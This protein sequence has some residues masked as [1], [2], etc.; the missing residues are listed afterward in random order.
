MVVPDPGQ[1][2]AA[3]TTTVA[4]ERA[5]MGLTGS[6]PADPAT[7]TESAVAAAVELASQALLVSEGSTS[8]AE[9]APP[10]GTGDQQNEPPVDDPDEPHDD[11]VP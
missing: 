10:P 2:E 3:A 5:K 4:Q 6:V 7:L 11:F 8:C 1:L 9:C